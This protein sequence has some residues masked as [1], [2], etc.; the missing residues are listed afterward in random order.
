MLRAD[1]LVRLNTNAFAT[2]SLRVTDGPTIGI[3]PQ[4]NCLN[5]GLDFFNHVTPQWRKGSADVGI[6]RQKTSAH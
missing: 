3:C 6:Q 4:E 1:A 5:N 2:T